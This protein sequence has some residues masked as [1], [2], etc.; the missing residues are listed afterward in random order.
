MAD[1]FET[2]ADK[3]TTYPDNLGTSLDPQLLHHKRIFNVFLLT[4]NPVLNYFAAELVEYVY[5]EKLPEG[6]MPQDI[7]CW[8]SHGNLEFHADFKQMVTTQGVISIWKD[9]KSYTST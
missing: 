4:T 9:A 5:N 7:N 3:S 8:D 1:F 2:Y 6:L